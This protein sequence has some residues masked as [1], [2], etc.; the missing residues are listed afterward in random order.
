M[1]QQ[2]E[3]P[4]WHIRLSGHL[5]KEPRHLTTIGPA[6]WLYLYLLLNRD[7]ITLR[8]NRRINSLSRCLDA[9]EATVKRWLKV[10][11]ENRYISIVYSKNIMK[12]TVPDLGKNHFGF[13]WKFVRL[14]SSKMSY[15]DSRQLKNDPEPSS[16]MSY[17][18][19]FFTGINSLQAKG[20]HEKVEKPIQDLFYSNK[21]YDDLKIK[22]EEMAKEKQASN[23]D[24]KILI[25]HYHNE[26]LTVHEFP[27]ITGS[28]AAGIF[29]H[30]LKTFSCEDLIILI[31]AYVRLKDENLK[32]HA[33]T[34][35]FFSDS[36]NRLQMAGVLKK[37][38]ASDKTAVQREIEIE[39][40][41]IMGNAE[42]ERGELEELILKVQQYKHK[43][44]E[45]P[46]LKLEV[47]RL[48]ETLGEKKRVEKEEREEAKAAI[49]AGNY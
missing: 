9:S 39:F 27:P 34:L 5:F 18:T 44:K 13:V 49:D 30:L 28:K 42:T 45:E 20:F 32:S 31:S 29:K 15:L 12:I 14:D 19:S 1:T 10:L 36:I 17:L 46:L 26:I 41:R 43:Y 25:D 47:D 33:Y 4:A 16:K 38:K 22:E 8:L 7:H 21:T 40:D 23:P 24:I 11:R 6:I 35:N 37:K 3:K 48:Y 2:K